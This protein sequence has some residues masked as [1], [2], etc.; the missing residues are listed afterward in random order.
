MKVKITYESGREYG[1]VYMAVANVNGQRASGFGGSPE[2]A[3]N[4]L[5]RRLDQI[6]NVP[7]MPQPEEVEIKEYKEEELPCLFQ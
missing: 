6:I 7:E 5:I 1:F 4:N 3:K 2:E